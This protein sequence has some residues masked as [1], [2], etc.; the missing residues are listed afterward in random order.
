MT[1]QHI[2]HRYQPHYCRECGQEF[3]TLNA[4]ALTQHSQLWMHLFG[5]HEGISLHDYTLCSRYCLYRAQPEEIKAE[6]MLYGKG[7]GRAEFPADRLL[8]VYDELFPPEES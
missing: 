5:S 8:S 4:Q 2:P 7:V 6:K 1:D 3:L